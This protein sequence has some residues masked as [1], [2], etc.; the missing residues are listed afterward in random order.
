M[1]NKF[2]KLWNC[3]D[4]RWE[5]IN[6]NTIFKIIEEDSHYSIIALTDNTQFRTDQVITDLANKLRN[7]HGMVD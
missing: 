1:E 5:I 3:A 7:F 4:K 2:I 6:T